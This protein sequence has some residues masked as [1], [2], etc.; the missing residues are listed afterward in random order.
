M[1]SSSKTKRTGLFQR[2]TAAF[3]LPLIIIYKK[4]SSIESLSCF[5]RRRDEGYP[6]AEHEVLAI[7]NFLLSKADSFSPLHIVLVSG[8][9]EDDVSSF[10]FKT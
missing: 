1:T 2:I 9:N 4:V 3:P 6:L 8:V 7:Q 10:Y 5:L